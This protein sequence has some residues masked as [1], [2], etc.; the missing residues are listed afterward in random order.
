MRFLI[1]IIC[2][3]ALGLFHCSPSEAQRRI[4]SGAK[5]SDWYRITVKPLRSV[6]P[7]SLDMPANVREGYRVFDSLGRLES[8]SK[9]GDDDL[10]SWAQHL[11]K[12]RL[13]SYLKYLYRMEDFDPF[14]FCEYSYA[15]DLDTGYRNSV[16]FLSHVLQHE[17]TAILQNSPSNYLLHA[18]EILH[19]R[20][21]SIRL[22]PN[23]PHRPGILFLDAQ[24]LDVLKGSGFQRSLQDPKRDSLY[25]IVQFSV[26]EGANST[27]TGNLDGY[28]IYFDA[29][30]GPAVGP[31]YGELH[32]SVGMEAIVFLENMIL[33][34]DGT[35]AGYDMHPI[36]YFDTQGGVYI[37]K[38][39]QINNLSGYWG[40]K[41]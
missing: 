2:I 20:I 29:P 21:K 16:T 9:W 31:T 26:N 33:D 38:G 18:D 25:P 30:L 8:F 12:Q 15:H 3:L 4:D 10:K 36:P 19:V 27:Y 37:V 24:V 22:D 17:G 11:D 32:L 41:K 5:S 13:F 35:L 39:G 28:E 40:K 1:H 14:L 23:T 34:Y 7:Y 6:S